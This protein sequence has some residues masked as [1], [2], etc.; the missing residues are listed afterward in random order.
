MWAAHARELAETL[1]V[2]S[3]TAELKTA[4]RRLDEVRRAGGDTSEV[5]QQVRVLAERHRATHD[6][7]N[8]VE[9]AEQ[10]LAELVAG[11]E[12]LA[13]QAAALALRPLLEHGSS[14]ELDRTVASLAGMRAALVELGG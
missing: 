6:A 13:V 12:T 8:L 14:A 9:Q 10:R 11:L 7:Q 1:D 3:S 2:E 4:R 5:E